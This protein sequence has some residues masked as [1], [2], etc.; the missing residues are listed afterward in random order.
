MSEPSPPFPLTP[1]HWRF[2]PSP[3]LA[4]GRVWHSPRRSIF[5]IAGKSVSVCFQSSFLFR[6]FFMVKQPGRMP[7][8]L[9]LLPRSRRLYQPSLPRGI[10]VPRFFR[11]LFPPPTLCPPLR[12]WNPFLPDTPISLSCLSF[13]SIPSCEGLRWLA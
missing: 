2:P 8:L 6:T 10:T 9:E 4:Q 13:P 11:H 5:R 3:L 1:S 12:P 7:S